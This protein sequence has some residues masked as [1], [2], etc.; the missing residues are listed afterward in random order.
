MTDDPLLVPLIGLKF[1]AGRAFDPRQP[2]L[3]AAVRRAGLE[4]V[5]YDAIYVYVIEFPAAVSS[6]IRAQHL[7]SRVTISLQE[8]RVPR[9]FLT[10]A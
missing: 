7:E 1:Q 2:K 9:R 10:R 4:V 8:E 3:I 6:A 5:A